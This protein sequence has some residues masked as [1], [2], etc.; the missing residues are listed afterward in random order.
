LQNISENYAATWW[1]KLASDF[2][3]LRG[4]SGCSE[5]IKF[6][7]ENYFEKHMSISTT[8]NK[9]QLMRIGNYFQ[10]IFKVAS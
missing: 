10:N 9:I 7:T 4:K 8:Y 3:S 1:Q 2:P 6:I 5:E